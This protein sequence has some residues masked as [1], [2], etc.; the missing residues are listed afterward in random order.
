ME[1]YVHIKKICTQSIKVK[2][3]K[4]DFLKIK[5]IWSTKDPVKRM[6]K[7]STEWE[8]MFASHVSDK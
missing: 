6:E 8:K 7:Q 2:I 5:N 3:D 4:L 1:T